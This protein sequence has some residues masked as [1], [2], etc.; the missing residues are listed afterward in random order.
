MPLGYD[1][2]DDERSFEQEGITGEVT[3]FPVENEKFPNIILIQDEAKPI[4]QH[5]MQVLPSMFACSVP[6]DGSSAS[7]IYIY[8][9]ENGKTIHIGRIFPRQVRAFLRLFSGNKVIGNLD[10]DT[11]LEGSY[12]YVLSE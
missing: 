7:P 6:T 1:S 4:P 2:Y 11:P 12:L 8:Y 3:R 9:S 5:R 10:K